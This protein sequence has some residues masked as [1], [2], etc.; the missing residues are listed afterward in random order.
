ML[1][2]HRREKRHDR[3]RAL[4]GE[5]GV[6]RIGRRE[7]VRKCLGEADELMEPVAGLFLERHRVA[8][9][10]GACIDLTGDHRGIPVLRAGDDQHLRFGA[11]AF[12]VDP[13]EAECRA[14]R[15][16]AVDRKPPSLEVRALLDVRCGVHVPGIG[17]LG[18]DIR[19]WCALLDRNGGRRDTDHAEL[20]VVADHALRHQIRRGER[21]VLDDVAVFTHGIKRG[22]E[23]NAAQTEARRGNRELL[24]SGV[25][26]GLAGACGR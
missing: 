22:E 14:R 5:L 20:E 24:G 8:D 7:D 11:R 6:D 15:L 25:G 18:H 23:R 2:E 21:R 9:L 17:E 16:L 13:V 19:D 12:L 26:R 10:D 4:R 1:L 3:L